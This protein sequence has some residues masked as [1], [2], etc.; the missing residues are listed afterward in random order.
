MVGAEAGDRS[1]VGG[2]I[3]HLHRR[4]ART[5]HDDERPPPWLAYDDDG[6]NGYND[7]GYSDNDNDRVDDDDDNGESC[8]L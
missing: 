3:W 5:H 7:N 1:G 6:D 4:L 8:C 2:A